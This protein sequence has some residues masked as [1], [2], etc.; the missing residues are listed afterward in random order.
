[1]QSDEQLVALERIR[2]QR[3][4]LDARLLPD[5]LGDGLPDLEGHALCGPEWDRFDLEAVGEPSTRISSS[6]SSP[7]VHRPPSSASPQPPAT[8][9]SPTAIRSPTRTTAGSR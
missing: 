4:A 3:H 5:R 1:M 2:L 7:T 6:A 9:S 8:T